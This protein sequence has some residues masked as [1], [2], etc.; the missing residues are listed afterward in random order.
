MGKSGEGDGNT[1]QF[2]FSGD[3]FGKNANPATP[4][5]LNLPT[6]NPTSAFGTSHASNSNSIGNNP[7]QKKIA[8]VEPLDF[9]NL[10]KM[11]FGKPQ[12]DKPKSSGLSFS[13]SANKVSEKSDT[14]NGSFAKNAAPFTFASSNKSSGFP[15]NIAAAPLFGKSDN[16]RKTSS[17]R[18]L[19]L[20]GGS[21]K[22]NKF[23]KM[24]S[25][26]LEFKTSASTGGSEKSNPFGKMMSKPLAFNTSTSKKKQGKDLFTKKSHNEDLFGKNTGVGTSIFGGTKSGIGENSLFGDS[27]SGGR[28]IF[29]ES[30]PASTGSNALFGGNSDAKMLFGKAPAPKSKFSFKEDDDDMATDS[31]METAKKTAD[32][33]GY[34]GEKKSAFSLS[35]NKAS[36]FSLSSSKPVAKPPVYT[37]PPIGRPP[38]AQTMS[39]RPVTVSFMDIPEIPQSNIENKAKQIGG[40]EKMCPDA[41]IQERREQKSVHVLELKPGTDIHDPDRFVKKYKRSGAGEEQVYSLTRTPE[42]CSKSLHY[43]VNK[44]LNRTDV[45]LGDIYH[46]IDDR[47]RAIVKDLRIQHCRDERLVEYH[48]LNIRLRILFDFILK[49]TEYEK[50]VFWTEHNSKGIQESF[51]DLIHLDQDNHKTP[52]KNLK[53]TLV[54]AIAFELG[55]GNHQLGKAMNMWGRA[56][57]KIRKDPDMKKMSALVNAIAHRNYTKFCKIFESLPLLVQMTLHDTLNWM[58]VQFLNNANKIKFLPEMGDQK[59]QLADMLQFKRDEDFNQFVEFYAVRFN[60]GHM[61]IFDMKKEKFHESKSSLLD[62]HTGQSYRDIVTT[63]MY[64]LVKSP[65]SAQQSDGE[66]FPSF[67]IP[68]KPKTQSSKPKP[69]VSISSAKEPAWPSFTFPPKTEKPSVPNPTEEKKKHVFKFPVKPKPA[70]KTNSFDFLAKKEEKNSPEP[71]TGS[72]ISDIF[73][74]NLRR[75]TIPLPIVSSSAHT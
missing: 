14:D 49:G 29:G 50:R 71:Q 73:N 70:P 45:D 7:F 22:A 74:T 12:S 72:P 48:V 63:D 9:S 11:D 67:Q 20:F 21:E 58:R 40:C 36:S 28:S 2:N 69:V 1:S 17:S 39:A 52:R 43:M 56:P 18:G 34:K 57:E 38:L 61:L 27:N 10:R 41:E 25:R 30:K 3:L 59:Q 42:W 47:L 46:F 31:E 37:K 33:F 5:N 53:E 23:G 6:A 54:L 51:S 32:L 16:E 8:T 15:S 19:N 55:K 35:N 68:P 44:V 66:M 75:E 26:P 65:K 62:D 60:K 4:P 24:T 64:S 13:T